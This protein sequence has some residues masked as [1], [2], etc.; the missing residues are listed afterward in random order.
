M[1]RRGWAAFQIV[2]GIEYIKRIGSLCR[3]KVSIKMYKS[4]KIC[5]IFDREERKPPK[6]EAI[7]KFHH[8][9]QR[10]RK[11]HLRSF[12]FPSKKYTICYFLLEKAHVCFFPRGNNIEPT[13]LDNRKADHSNGN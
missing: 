1:I 4:E 2:E 3:T 10:I 7:L 6:T 5:S 13:V 9:I 8:Q 11:P 12:K